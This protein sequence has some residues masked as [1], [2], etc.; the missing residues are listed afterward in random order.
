MVEPSAKHRKRC[1]KPWKTHVF[2]GN[3]I[4]K[5]W[6]IGYFYILFP[7]VVYKSVTMTTSELWTDF[8]WDELTLI[9]RWLW[10][11]WIV[12][13]WWCRFFRG[14]GYHYP[15]IYVN[16]HN[17][18]QHECPWSSI[19]NLHHFPWL[20]TTIRYFPYGFVWKRWVYSHWNSHL[21]GIMISKTIGY[22]GVHNIFSNKPILPT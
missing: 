16:I 21:V 20:S 12:I 7:H 5:W 13:R 14:Y 9:V 10:L 17:D 4:Y 15:S 6:S 18:N 19:I 3:M 2:P 1:G 11:E 8:F 22:N